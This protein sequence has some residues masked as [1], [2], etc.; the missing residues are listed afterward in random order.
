MNIVLTEHVFVLLLWLHLQKNQIYIYK[1]AWSA[2]TWFFILM[3][4]CSN[5]SGLFI[6]SILQWPREALLS[7][8]KTFFKNIDLGNE[9]MKDRFSEMC[10][11]IH[12]SVTEMADQYFAE[13]RRRYYTTPTSYLELINLYLSMLGEKRKQLV[14]VR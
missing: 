13:L 5:N 4:N 11:E 10:V 3:L 7:V 6:L 14:S 2:H 1:N 9:E 12:V 8:S